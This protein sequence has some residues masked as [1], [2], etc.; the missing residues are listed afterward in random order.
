MKWNPTALVKRL[1]WQN[2]WVL[3]FSPNTNSIFLFISILTLGLKNLSQEKME[4]YEEENW[5]KLAT[6]KREKC[7]FFFHSSWLAC[8][9]EMWSND[10]DD[11]NKPV[12][13]KSV[14][15]RICFPSLYHFFFIFKHICSFSGKQIGGPQLFKIEQEEIWTTL[16][17][18]D[19]RQDTLDFFH[20]N[21]GRLF[22]LLVLASFSVL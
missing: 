9:V 17:V 12:K 5:K 2:G 19:S 4:S 6:V 8:Y 20:V 1:G 15:I 21:L 7:L 3:F 14:Q 13:E 10:N 11:A 18:F 22:L 16:F